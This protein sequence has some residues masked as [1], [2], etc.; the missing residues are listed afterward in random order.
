MEERI[1]CAAIWLKEVDRAHHRPINTPGG[2]VV[3][4][5]R[6]GHC[7]SQIVALTG[8]RLPEQGEHVQGFLTNKN[9]FVDRKEAAKIWVA[10]GGKLNYSDEDLYSEDIY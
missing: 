9:R 10:N 4:G 2:V 1:L 6:H 8:K 7:I 3:C 5:H